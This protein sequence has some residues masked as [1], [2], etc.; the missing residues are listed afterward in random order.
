MTHWNP[1]AGL[2]GV[3]L[4]PVRS[5]RMEPTLRGGRDAVLYVPVVRFAYDALYVLD[6]GDDELVVC[7]C[8]RSPGGVRLISDNKLYSS[9][10]VGKEEFSRLV[11]GLVVAELKSSVGW[12][13]WPERRPTPRDAVSPFAALGVQLGREPDRTSPANPASATGAD[14]LPATT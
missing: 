5:D 12:L 13:D 3:G 7:R 8:G 14:Q 10:E 11:R 6:G 4:L 2:S 1:G 9:P